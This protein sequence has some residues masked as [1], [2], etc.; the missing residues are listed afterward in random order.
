[1]IVAFGD[2]VTSIY[3]GMVIFTILG[4]MSHLMQLPVDQVVKSGEW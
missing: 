4:Y 2:G 3:A 1:M